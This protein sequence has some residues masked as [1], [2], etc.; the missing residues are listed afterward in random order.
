MVF[1]LFFFQEE[2]PDDGGFEY[3]F[4]PS[5]GSAPSPRRRKQ[6]TVTDWSHNGERNTSYAPPV[7]GH[8]QHH[9]TTRVSPAGVRY[10][11]DQRSAYIDFM[12]IRTPATACPPARP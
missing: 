3:L 12:T 11:L 5:A 6:L 1:G 7:L 9:R 8:L 10:T 4:L 2:K